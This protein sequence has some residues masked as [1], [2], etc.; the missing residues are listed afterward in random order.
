M[1]PAPS[2]TLSGSL[3]V[4]SAGCT[5]VGRSTPCTGGVAQKRTAGS[6]LYFPRRVG[7]LSGSGMPGSMQTRSPTAS[8]VTAD[9]TSTTSPDASWPR[10]IGSRTMK[11]PIPPWA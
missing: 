1:A 3:N 6:R 11:G 8:E 4:K 7:R 2:D 5:T 9:P 10:T